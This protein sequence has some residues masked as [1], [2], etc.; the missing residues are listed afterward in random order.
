RN[1]LRTPARQLAETLR[2]G[3]W[4]PFATGAGVFRRSTDLTREQFRA[5]ILAHAHAYKGIFVQGVVIDWS[6]DL[7][8]RPQHMA[9]AFAR[10]GYLVI[11]QTV[12][13]TKD[14][15]TGVRQVAP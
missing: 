14:D 11:Y 9:A 3:A 1:T 10:L 2:D 6:V 15:V 12:N 13:W 5:N 8:Q 7:Y 4:V